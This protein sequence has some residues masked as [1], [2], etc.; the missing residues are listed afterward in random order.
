MFFRLTPLLIHLN[1]WIEPLK[2]WILTANY[3]E[4]LVSSNDFD[5]IKSFAEKI[6]TNRRLLDRK[7]FFDFVR[8]FDLIPKY[9]EIC[10]ASGQTNSP[11]NDESLVWS[12]SRD[13]NPGPPGPK[14]GALASCATLRN[15]T[16]Q[17]PRALPT[18][19]HPVV[20]RAGLEP[21]RWDYHQ[22]ILSLSCLPV[23]TPRLIF[24][25]YCALL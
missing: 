16:G 17:E 20:P 6:G 8:P 5:E 12:E 7:I 13:S 19:L 14:P 21:A 25:L 18:K 10:E 22:K 11:R 24:I 2:N 4:K 9:K 1:N 15:F 3:A 23:P